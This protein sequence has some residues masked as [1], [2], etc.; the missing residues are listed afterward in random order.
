[1]LASQFTAYEVFSIIS[2]I[3]LVVVA[4]LPGME[5]SE[6]F[7][8]LLGGAFFIG[9]G[10]YVAQQTSGTWYFPVWIFIIPIGA[11]IYGIVSVVSW[12]SENSEQRPTPAARPR[13]PQRTTP[14]TANGINIPAQPGTARSAAPAHPAVHASELA[15]HP[16]G[17]HPDPYGTATYRYWDGSAWTA[18]VH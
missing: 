7:W 13:P 1:M 14:A 9:Y 5:A 2:G 17:W 18:H 6:R 8:S 4:L 10:I 3:C 11:V 16:A 12:A 15:D